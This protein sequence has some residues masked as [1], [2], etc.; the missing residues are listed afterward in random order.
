MSSDYPERNESPIKIRYVPGR[1]L[2]G[3]QFDELDFRI[4][5]PHEDFS[6]WNGFVVAPNKVLFRGPLLNHWEYAERFWNQ[7]NH[8]GK[9]DFPMDSSRRDAD[10]LVE[11]S[12]DKNKELEETWFEFEI[13]AAL[14]PS[15]ETFLNNTFFSASATDKLPKEIRKFKP[16]EGKRGGLRAFVIFPIVLGEPVQ[17]EREEEE[18]EIDVWEI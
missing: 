18:E 1:K 16:E 10:L 4:D 15:G 12:F 8:D 14:F 13:P 7:E 2:N 5:I 6:L 11:R 3:L 17:I 9:S